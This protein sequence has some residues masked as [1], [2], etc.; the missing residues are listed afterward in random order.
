LA[1]LAGKILPTLGCDNVEIKVGDGFLGWPQEAPFDAI[2]VTAAAP[3]MPDILTDHLDIG[4]RMV[5]PL[6][7]D[8]F[9]R[10]FLYKIVKT[11]TGLEEDNLYEVR[12]VPMI[13]E[14]EK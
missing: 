7:T 8:R 10:Q 9:G 4:G 2:I 14:I 3:R 11:D 12:F 13:G 6:S 1:V 5:I